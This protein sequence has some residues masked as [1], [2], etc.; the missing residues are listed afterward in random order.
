[1]EELIKEIRELHD[2][3]RLITLLFCKTLDIDLD[4]FKI[5]NIIIDIKYTFPIVIY[6]EASIEIYYEIIKKIEN[7]FN[8]VKYET[9]EFGE[10]N[11]TGW[12][13]GRCR[14]HF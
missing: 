14:L 13:N 8:Y 1:M 9:F 4:S 12:V 5:S 6:F 3:P 10:F 2:H 7:Y 11:N